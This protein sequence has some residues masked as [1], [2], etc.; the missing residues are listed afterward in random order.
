MNKLKELNKKYYDRT[1][2]PINVK[3][4]DRIYLRTE[5]YNKLQ[6]LRK[7]FIIT[8][9]LDTNVKSKFQKKTVNASENKRK[10]LKYP[11]AKI[12]F[13]KNAFIIQ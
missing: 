2:N 7:P 6:Q 12:I 5:P 1:A 13:S 11:K 4:G 10:I 9:I 8:E 3:V